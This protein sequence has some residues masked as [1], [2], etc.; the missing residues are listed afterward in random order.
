[1]IVGAAY[2]SRGVGRALVEHFHRWAVSR[3]ANLLSVTAYAEN[4]GARSF[5]RALGY[6]DYQVVMHREEA[7]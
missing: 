7:P 1:M 3:E 4:T 2:R 5:Y 6:G